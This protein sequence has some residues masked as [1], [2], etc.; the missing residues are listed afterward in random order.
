MFKPLAEYLLRNRMVTVV[1][2]LALSAAPHFSIPFLYSMGWIIMGLVA[3]RSGAV[4]SLPLLLC[5]LLP[6]AVSYAHHG[7]FSPLLLCHWVLGPVLMWLLAGLLGYTV[8]WRLTLQMGAGLAALL[9]LLFHFVFPHQVALFVMMLKPMVMPMLKAKSH[10]DPQVIQL[11]WQWLQMHA[12]GLWV[13]MSYLIASILLIMARMWQSWAFN[14]G[15]WREEFLHIRFD[16]AYAAVFFSVF[17]V[18]FFGLTWLQ[19][20]TLVLLWSFV[21]SGMSAMHALLMVWSKENV[22]WIMGF[23]LLVLLFLTMM[24]V[25]MAL[26]GMVDSV[27]NVRKLQRG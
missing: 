5:T 25:V 19:N 13:G 1:V 8:S 6:V 27:V 17:L 10:A 24:V 3:L 4:V 9:A 26:M 15:G 2:V 22:L 23:Y 20:V 14:P 12:A 18:S 11:G 21:I 7:V 16:P